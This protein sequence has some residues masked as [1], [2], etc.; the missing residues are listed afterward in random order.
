MKNYSFNN[1]ILIDIY[2][3]HSEWQLKWE[4]GK[5]WKRFL[6]NNFRFYGSI[7]ITIYNNLISMKKDSLVSAYIREILISSVLIYRV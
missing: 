1:K 3:N 4:K 6:K 2:S 5:L 7:A